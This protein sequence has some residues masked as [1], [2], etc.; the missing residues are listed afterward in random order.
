MARRVVT[1]L[2]LEGVR[3]VVDGFQQVAQG[4]KQSGDSIKKNL[5][6]SL[7]YI[8]KHKDSIETLGKGFTKAGALAAGGLAAITKAA[9]GWET[10]FAGVE[11]TVD[12]TREQLADLE[13]QLRELARSMPATH[14]G[15]AGV[16]EAAGQFGI[17][18]EGLAAFTKTMIQL[19]ETTNLTADGAATQIAHIT[20]IMATSVDDVDNFASALVA[21]GNDGASTEA[22]ILA[23][24]TR[25]AGTANLVR[26][27]EADVLAYANAMASVGI[28]A[29]AGGTAMSMT[30]RQMDADVRE[31]AESLDLIAK[32]AGMTA[33]EFRQAWGENAADA[34]RRFVEGLGQVSKQGGNVNAILDELGFTGMRQSDTLLRLAGASDLLAESLELGKQAW[35]ENSALAE[36]YAKRAQTT[37]AQARVAWNNIKDS[38]ITAGQ[39]MLPVVSQMADAVADVARRFGEMPDGA[40]QFGVGILAVV[41]TAGLGMGALTKLMTTIA[42]VKNALVD[43][44]IKGKT[45]SLGLGAIGIA[46]TIAGLAFANYLGKQQELR[47]ATEAYTD[48][49]KAQGS[50]IGEQTRALAAQRLEEEGALRAAEL[51]GIEVSSVTDAVHGNADAYERITGKINETIA[52]WENNDATREEYVAALDLNEALEAEIASMEGGIEA[53]ARMDAAAADST[54]GS[55]AD[56]AAKAQQTAEIEQQTQSLRELIAETQ[57]YGSALLALS[58]SQIGVEAAFASAAESAAEFGHNLDITTEGGRANQSALDSAAA[59]GMRLLGAMAETDATSIELVATQSDLIERFVAASEAMGGNAEEA[60]KLAERLFALPEDVTIGVRVPGLTMT[61]DEVRAFQAE[62]DKLPPEKQVE[63][64]SLWDSQQYQAALDALNA[65][66]GK[67]AYTF[68]HTSYTSAAGS[69]GTGGGPVPFVEADGDVL[70]FY[71]NG[72]LRRGGREHHAAQIVP[73]GSWRVFGEPETEGEAYIPLAASKRSRS[74]SILA[75]VADRFGYELVRRFADGDVVG[76]M[77]AAP[78]W[79]SA[80][81]VARGREVALTIAPQFAQ[82]VDYQQAMRQTFDEAAQQFRGYLNARR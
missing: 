78:Q 15:I 7:K 18:R 69:T 42:D 73:A 23:L 1:R 64:R 45:A 76:G 75:E 77:S 30:W 16:A 60:R 70:E 49:I 68:V 31:G 54:E 48:A 82:G 65:I 37:E 74:T 8:D 40:Q 72:G 79:A 41:A 81:P 50:A 63:I 55:K 9:M 14:E 71:R 47:A 62:I 46:L 66:N 36:E 43:L 11:K 5:S 3:A 35:A 39:S 24:A 52:A 25:L 33:D 53:R 22:E 38:A 28:E 67:T 21:L 32:T 19:D 44:G 20:N 34:T 51:L 61:A 27:S 12:G 17:A 13:G 59:A 26:I 4:A 57:G 2:A 6:D 80:A 58:G 10:Q 29:E 56:A